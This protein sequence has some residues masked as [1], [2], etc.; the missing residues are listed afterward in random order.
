MAKP[1][2][3]KTPDVATRIMERMVRMPPKQHKEM[4]IGKRKT[5]DAESAPKLYVTRPAGAPTYKKPTIIIGIEARPDG[6]WRPFELYRLLPD[7]TIESASL[8]SSL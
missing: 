4:K 1:S 2:D 3:Q 5:V 8:S 6:T 7:G